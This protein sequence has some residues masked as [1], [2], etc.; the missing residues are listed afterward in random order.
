MLFEWLKSKKY[1]TEYLSFPDYSTTIG[2]EIRAFLNGKKEYSKEARH[3]LYAANRY[4]HKEEI[5]NWIINKRK[6][7]V[8]N[9]YT[10]SNIAYGTAEGLSLQWVKDIESQMPQADYVFLLEATPELSLARKKKNRDIFEADLTFL[11]RVSEVYSALVE[12]GKWF[13]IKGDR[14]VDLIHYEI[15]RLFEELVNLG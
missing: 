1:D 5:E 9:R 6:V 2:Q 8:V 4:E 13:V 14:P 10:D 12:K 3:I 15:S 11:K 7:V